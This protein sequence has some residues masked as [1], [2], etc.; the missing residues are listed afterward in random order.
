[1]V[2]DPHV[3]AAWDAVERFYAE[4]DRGLRDLAAIER[5]ELLREKLISKGWVTNFNAD[6]LVSL[7]EEHYQGL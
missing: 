7:I 1:M 6:T 5:R 2:M 3:K 4:N